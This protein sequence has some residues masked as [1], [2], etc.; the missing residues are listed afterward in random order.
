MQTP[1]TLSEILT[2]HYAPLRR[3]SPR[4]VALYGYTLTAF[5]RWLATV[6]DREPGPPR[7]ADLD[8]L[9][10]ARFVAAREVER[11]AVTAKKDRTQ[12]LALWRY[13]ARKR[14]VDQFPELP[15]MRVPE[16]IPRA[17][18]AADLDRLLEYFA[19]I[20]GQVA[21]V[22]ASSWWSS[23]VR[24]LFETGGRITET[25]SVEWTDLDI[26]ARTILLRAENRKARTRDIVREIST[27]TAATLSA[28]RRPTGR[29]WPW[30][31]TDKYLW[32]V[33]RGHCGR[34]GVT[35]RKGFH[36]IRKATCSYTAAAGGDA[37]ALAD[38]ADAATTRRHYLDPSIV[39]VESNL[40]RLPRLGAGEHVDAA[41][42]EEQALRAG[43][44]TGIA[45][46]SAGVS[47]PDRAAVAALARASGFTAHSTLY[48]HGLALAW[49]GRDN[50][51][52]LPRR[53]AVGCDSSPIATET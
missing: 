50:A 21:D 9:V 36:A 37:T 23:L 43:Y 15:P 8:D 45:L 29:V 2:T 42:G 10:V 44:Q 22:S 35:Y 20:G 11:C 28:R 18:T 7:V 39:K 52:I 16:R 13:C 40:A 3:L 53:S 47:R 49:G 46:A 24:V 33:F 34:A 12:L 4:T 6:P 17:Y 26:E 1:P 38:H 51:E 30:A 19:G 32:A 48:G 14:L 31:M 25:L 5:D 27:E 41:A